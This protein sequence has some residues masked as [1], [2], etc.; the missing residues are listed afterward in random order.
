MDHDVV[1][2]P[3]A[4]F[5]VLVAVTRAVDRATLRCARISRGGAWERVPKAA[6]RTETI[7]NVRD[8]DQ[9]IRQAKVQ[10]GP[11]LDRRTGKVLVLSRA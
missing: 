3:F 10:I 8:I 2:P 9:L 4:R 5:L 1:L 7:R 11:G 6:K